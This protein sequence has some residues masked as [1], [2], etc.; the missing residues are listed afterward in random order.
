[1]KRAFSC[2]LV[3]G[4][5]AV[6]CK[7]KDDTAEPAPEKKPGSAAEAP[8]GLAPAPADEPHNTTPPP[9]MPPPPQPGATGSA[10]SGSAGSGSA[11]APN[12]ATLISADGVGP[13]TA[14]T[15]PAQLA[16]IFPSPD[17]SIDTEKPG[18]EANTF[19]KYSVA[20]GSKIKLF[21][22]ADTSIDAKVPA[23]VDIVSPT[24]VTAKGIKVTNTVGEVQTAYPD[25]GC[26]SMKY[27]SNPEGLEQVVFCASPSLPNIQFW[28][29]PNKIKEK[30]GAIIPQ[31]ISSNTFIKIVWRPQ[32]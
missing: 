15:D 18:P 25:L 8:H 21:V 23:R 12:A 28:I 9:P 17:W 26:K 3:V 1:M 27:G 16:T 6:A 29:D 22:L 14:T 32:H 4:L 19:N 2:V 20:Q 30:E 11:A 7:K 10:G 13:I 24:F 31:K 5:L